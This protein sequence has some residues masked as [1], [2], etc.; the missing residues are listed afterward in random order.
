MSARA[1]TRSATSGAGSSASARE[2]AAAGTRAGRETERDHL[3]R[4]PR[5][6]SGLGH[7]HPR[8][9]ES[10]PRVDCSS[11]GS[12]TS[13]MAPPRFSPCDRVG[14]RTPPPSP[15]RRT[16]APSWSGERTSAP[17]PG[18]PRTRRPWT[19]R[20]GDGLRPAPGPR[21]GPPARP[22][23]HGHDPRR[24]SLDCGNGAGR[25][26]A[27]RP[28]GPRPRTPTRP[29]GAGGDR[30]RRLT[31]RGACPPGRWRSRL[32]NRSPPRPRACAWR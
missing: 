28:P 2:D 3:G 14:P 26:E 27:S 29:F 24:G 21:I 9:R 11:R 12:A 8:R 17:P 5:G 16:P 4:V 18:Q 25:G 32:R 19:C 22:H 23:D 31:L 20:P 7:T 1:E 30:Q 15:R 6:P 13:G 10:A